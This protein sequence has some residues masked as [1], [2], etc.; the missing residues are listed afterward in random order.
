MKARGQWEV[1]IAEDG[2]KGIRMR[3]TDRDYITELENER[4]AIQSILARQPVGMTLSSAEAFERI[5]EIW[6]VLDG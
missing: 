6:A 1:F 2:E 3:L 4:I 5:H